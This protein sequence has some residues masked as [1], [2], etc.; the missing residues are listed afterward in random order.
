MGNPKGI[1]RDFAAL[2][3]RRMEAARLFQQG[4]NNSEI[5]RR[6]KVTNQT[7]S[8]WRKAFRNSGIQAL[9]KAGRAGRRPM[10]TP[11]QK[12]ALAARLQSPSASPGSAPW[13]SEQVARLIESEFGVRYHPGHV[14]KLLR[15]WKR[16]SQPP[17]A[18]DKPGPGD[19]RD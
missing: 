18:N 7:V 19:R 13:T 8:R 17:G 16:A 15:A 3:S 6:L 14:W 1:P 2:E 5:G 11:D 4:L 12:R 10:L 9:E